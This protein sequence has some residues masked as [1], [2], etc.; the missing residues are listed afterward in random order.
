MADLDEARLAHFWHA[1]M[2]PLVG[3]RG[4]DRAERFYEVAGWLNEGVFCGFFDR[5]DADFVWVKFK[6]EVG[7]LPQVFEGHV[8]YAV[9]THV[10]RLLRTDRPFSRGELMPDG[11]QKSF[12]GPLMA[13]VLMLAERLED[14][15]L[16][17]AC[18]N[19]ILFEPRSTWEDLI[20]TDPSEYAVARVLDTEPV[21]ASDIDLLV[22]GYGRLLTHMDA[23][24]EFF[25]FG[26]LRAKR[27]GGDFNSY[28]ERI[29]ALNA[30]RVPLMSRDGRERFSSLGARFDE[31]VVTSVV[32]QLQVAD[33]GGLRAELQRT[34]A[35]LAES[36]S[37]HH[38]S[39]L[40]AFA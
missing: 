3:Y 19:A 2:A 30:W 15:S 22:A 11:A 38:L 33:D 9:Q 16:A 40:L 18:A 32:R 24:H 29:G 13:H 14:D 35:S 7:A 34:R 23:S 26:K 4:P 1:R 17:S 8:S 37:Q 25:E 28:L 6:G 20:K 39:A 27:I 31:L 36:W 5:R 12:E 21:G 10:E